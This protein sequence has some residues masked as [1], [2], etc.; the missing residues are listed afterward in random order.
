M[1]FLN[2]MGLLGSSEDDLQYALNVFVG[3]FCKVRMRI[4]KCCE[5]GT[6]SAAKKSSHSSLNVSGTPLRQVEIFNY[7]I[8]IFMGNRRQEAK[9]RARI[10]SAS[11]V[12]HQHQHSIHRRGKVDKKANVAIFNLVYLWL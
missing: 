4:S 8:V 3:E 5:D 12:T 7:L 6:L 1:I 9:L 11:T 10:I 2:N